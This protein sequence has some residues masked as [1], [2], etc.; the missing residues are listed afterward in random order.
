MSGSYWSEGSKTME[1]YERANAR[2]FGLLMSI[3]IHTYNEVNILRSMISRACSC[4]SRCHHNAVEVTLIALPRRQSIAEYIEVVLQE[5]T[6]GPQET[7]SGGPS[8]PRAMTFLSVSGSESPDISSV[9][10]PRVTLF[11]FVCA[12]PQTHGT[13]STIHL[14]AL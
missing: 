4:S 5:M 6:A 1:I 8:H 14:I 13:A 12:H 2:N 9:A 11:K 7:L 10:Q 3:Y